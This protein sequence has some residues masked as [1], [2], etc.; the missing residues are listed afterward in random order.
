MVSSP[1]K[2][3]VKLDLLTDIDILLLEE[4]DIRGGICHVIHQYMKNNNKYKNDYNKNKGS[5]Y[6]NF[7]D[8]ECMD[9]QCHKSC[10]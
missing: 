5:V 3:K 8:G 4:K 2:L 7:W 1:K 10:L 9:G 6:L